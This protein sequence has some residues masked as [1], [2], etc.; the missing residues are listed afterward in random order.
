MAPPGGPLR[1]PPST[2]PFAAGLAICLACGGLLDAPPTDWTAYAG[3]D[4][5]ADCELPSEPTNEIRM[6]MVFGDP[7]VSAAL[8]EEREIHDD[9][10]V[11][12]NQ[13][14]KGRDEIQWALAP[15]SPPSKLHDALTGV[16]PVLADLLA[17]S[18][19]RG[20]STGEWGSVVD[21][22][23][24]S[25]C[26][27]G[28]LRLTLRQG[29]ALG[30]EVQPA[31]LVS[32]SVAESDDLEPKLAALREAAKV[33]DTEPD[34]AGTV[35][36]ASDALPGGRVCLFTEGPDERTDL[37][38]L[39]ERLS[40]MLGPDA[41]GLPPM[42]DRRA[43]PARLARFY[44]TDFEASYD[45]LRFDDDRDLWDSL[46]NQDVL[47]RQREYVRGNIAH[48]FGSGTAIRCLQVA[49]DPAVGEPQRTGCA[50]ALEQRRK[51][52]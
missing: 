48:A 36:A 33:G 32:L 24:E 50:E 7:L 25:V 15:G 43:L 13:R 30:L 31:A 51:A 41:P 37:P 34:L 38:K 19:V 4:A 27:R 23:V 46:G 35:L 18:A 39:A 40:A 47:T 16:D 28:P 22:E 11:R 6:G 45:A 44:A 21:S 52:E 1:I 5:G 8:R 20:A 49:A 9:A 29:R 12:L 10:W 42:S 26:G 14:M 3:C 2:A 17:W